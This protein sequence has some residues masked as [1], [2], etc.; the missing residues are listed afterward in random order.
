MRCECDNDGERKE[1]DHERN[2]LHGVKTKFSLVKIA[3]FSK[4]VKKELCG[5]ESARILRSAENLSQLVANARPAT[6][7]DNVK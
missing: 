7:T 6:R 5:T 4:L 3:C 2:D 1:S